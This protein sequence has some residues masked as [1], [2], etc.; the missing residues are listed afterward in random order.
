MSELLLLDSLLQEVEATLPHLVLQNKKKWHGGEARDSHLRQSG[1][2]LS[3]AAASR[4][5]PAR[6]KGR[7]R[8]Q[9]TGT[10]PGK[11]TV[12]LTTT[13]PL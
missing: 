1:T 6:P 8:P 9:G 3:L 12:H 4:E 2:N 7:Q 5:L 13:C 10:I 11:T